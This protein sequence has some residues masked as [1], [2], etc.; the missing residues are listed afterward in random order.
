M[1]IER[2]CKSIFY[3]SFCVYTISWHGG[4]LGMG[5]QCITSYSSVASASAPSSSFGFGPTNSRSCGTLNNGKDPPWRDSERERR[6]VIGYKMGGTTSF[7]SALFNLYLS[8]TWNSSRTL[9]LPGLGGFTS[10]LCSRQP[11]S[12]SQRRSLHMLSRRLRDLCATLLQLGSA[13][14]TCS[15][16]TSWTRATL[17]MPMC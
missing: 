6:L 17:R 15:S 5:W 3:V 11:R 16:N 8:N 10:V 7:S 9:H 14:S 12:S 2:Y 4:P 1:S 13:R